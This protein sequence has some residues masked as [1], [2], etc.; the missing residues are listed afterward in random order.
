METTIISGNVVEKSKSR[1][2]RRPS[3]RSMRV[4]GNSSEKK[5]VGN[6][7]Y[8]K[9]ALARIINCNFGPGDL[10]LTLTYR[11]GAMEDYKE[12]DHKAA[13][14]L[15]RLAYRIRK[16]GGALKWIRNT[17][18]L[19]G[20][21]GE[22]VRI[23]HHLIVSGEWFRVEDKALWLG[24]QKVEDIWGL[25]FVD[26]RFLRHQEDFKPLAN[27][28]V[29][30][31]RFLP[32]EKKWHSSRN[33]K[34][35]VVRKRLISK[36]GPLKAPSGAKLLHESEYDIESG[37]HYIRYIK[38]RKKD[39]RRKIGGHKEMAVAMDGEDDERGGLD[40]LS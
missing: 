36:S 32:D 11:D 35:P 13:L 2:A 23:H 7:E 4:K 28:I 29:N 19:D 27:Y 37:N 3:R 30:Q 6:R 14:F 10:W 20:D 15:E 9:R 1:L 18:T 38:P 34:K 5:Q 39:P 21:T 33:M 40:G 25:G 24:K 16:L 17:S 8:A 31:G 26:F 22:V 12:A